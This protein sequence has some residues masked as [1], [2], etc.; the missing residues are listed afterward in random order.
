[1]LWKA[2]EVDPGIERNKILYWSTTDV[3]VL[4]VETGNSYCSGASKSGIAHSSVGYVVELAIAAIVPMCGIFLCFSS[5]I[6]SKQSGGEC[7]IP[8]E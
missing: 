7:G 2:T 3:K 6:G 1:M 8:L 4:L 5:Q